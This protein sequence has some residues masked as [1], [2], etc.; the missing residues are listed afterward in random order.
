MNLFLMIQTQFM[1][2][3]DS[4]DAANQVTEVAIP[5]F[6]LTLKGGWIMI[7]IALL[8]ILAIYIFIERY[9]AIR[10]KSVA[11]VLN[12]NKSACSVVIKF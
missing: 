8:S 4:L 10:A 12:F 6:E 9:F 2:Q 7:P 1:A 3:A 11:A 5:I